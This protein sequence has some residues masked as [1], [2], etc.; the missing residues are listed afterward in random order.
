M[1][2]KV[3]R[4]QAEQAGFD[5]TVKKRIRAYFEEN[6]ISRFANTNM[7]LKTIFIVLLYIVP[8]I[9][10]I[11]GLVTNPWLIFGLWGVMGIATAFA[12]VNI[13]HDA[14]HGCYSRY[15]WVNTFIGHASNLIGIFPA[16][17]KLQH[18]VLHH[19]YTNIEGADDDIDAPPILRLSPHDP[20]KK[21]HKGQYIYAWFLYMLLSIMR[22]T[23]K[24]FKQIF[25]YSKKGLIK[26]KKKTRG[27]LAELIMWKVIYFG[28]LI[29]LPSILLPQS[30]FFFIGCWAFMHLFT[31]FILSII[32]QLAHVMPDCAY[33]LPNEAG[34]LED[35]WAVHQM[36]TT[37]NFATGNKFITWWFGG[38]NFQVEH[39]LLSNICHVHY[40]NLAPIVEKTAKEF[41]VPYYSQSTFGS[42]LVSHGRMLYKLGRVEV[43]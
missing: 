25:S 24:E 29:I 31:G 22:T 40:P 21:I 37:T 12:G 16:M 9:L 4:F 43:A 2:R 6:D 7:V 10:F 41:G 34:R 17:W 14:N 26:S 13:M 35:T 20:L 38:L 11:T 23:V 8:Y 36:Y 28:Y 30:V 3:F 18:N 1:D 5:K 32:F 33:P 19:T 15:S 39:H 27:Y 42:A